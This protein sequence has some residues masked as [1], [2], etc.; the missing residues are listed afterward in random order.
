[1]I[2]S[3]KQTA[4]YSSLIAAAAM[5]IFAAGAQAGTNTAQN[6]ARATEAP[7]ITVHYESSTDTQ[8]LYS[9]LQSA[10]AAVC[11]QHEGRE[12]RHLSETR[13][14]YEQALGNA[15]AKVD[16][17]ALTSLHYSVTDMRLAEH[18]TNRQYRS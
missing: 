16:N 2:N 14:C 5:A 3:L 11:R 6:M 8:Q 7:R 1:M 17:A 9:Q 12:L 15:V 10:A 13:A 18:D 4:R